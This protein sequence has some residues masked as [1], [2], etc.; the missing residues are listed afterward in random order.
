MAE[1]PGY[2]TLMACEQNRHDCAMT[3]GGAMRWFLGT[4]LT[5][6]VLVASAAFA[7]AMRTNREVGEVATRTHQQELVDAQQDQ[8]LD[9]LEQK[10]D[11]G[12]QQV[13]DEL[14]K[15]D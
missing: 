10:I 7:F 8:R 5:I 4:V 12:F 14:K 1:Q 3:R 13:L 2:V 6:A 15:K 11:T 9:R